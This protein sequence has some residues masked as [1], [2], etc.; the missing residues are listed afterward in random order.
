M[1]VQP[2]PLLVFGQTGQV[3]RALRDLRPDALFLGREDADLSDPAACAA[4]IAKLAP[5]AV[6]NAAAYTDVDGAEADRDTAH[7]VNAIAPTAMARA[8]A[9][10]DIPFV[11]I[12]TDYVFDGADDAPVSSDAP[13]AP[14]NVYGRTKRDGERGIQEVGGRYAI[15]RT[16]WVFS[17]HGRNFVTTMLRLAKTRDNLSVVSDQVGGPTPARA[18]AEACLTIAAHLMTIPSDSGI[19]HF[20]GA[21]DVS[22]AN[23]AREIFAQS[24]R[25]VAVH[26]IPSSAYPTLAQRPLNSRLDCQRT[27]EIF[28]LRRPNWAN[29]LT[30]VFDT[31]KELS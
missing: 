28:G 29:A 12:S 8:C 13:T 10:R 26:D 24:G 17:P 9:A 11:H 1:T 30:D 27:E 25:D 31:L 6:I 5:S 14:L 19:Y 20:T 7:L 16:S 21:P 2:G 15:L 18:I 3:A 4:Q 22:W 23:F